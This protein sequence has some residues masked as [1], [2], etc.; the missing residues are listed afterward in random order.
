[1]R[2]ESMTAREADGDRTGRLRAS[3]RKEHLGITNVKIGGSLGE[4]GGGDQRI[5]RGETHPAFGPF[6]RTRRVSDW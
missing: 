1:V 5:L 6:R 2:L 4:W 3:K